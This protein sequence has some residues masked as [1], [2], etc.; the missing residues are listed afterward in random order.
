MTNEMSAWY[1]D[2]TGTWIS[3]YG[4]A[5]TDDAGNFTINSPENIQ[6]VTDF[7]ALYDSGCFNTGVKASVFRPSFIAGDVATLMDNAN[8]AYT[9]VT[10]GGSPTS[11]WAPDRCR[12]RPSTRACSSCT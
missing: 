11:S 2:F 8:A 4:G 7:K 5:W 12:S 1:E 9:Y 10:G 3:G 6:A